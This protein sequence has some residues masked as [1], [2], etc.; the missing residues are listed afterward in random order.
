MQK[1]VEFYS[2]NYSFYPYA[3][4]KFTDEKLRDIFVSE[5]IRTLNNT[6]DNI[7]EIEKNEDTSVII[8]VIDYDKSYL[9]GIIGKLED[10]ENGLLKRLRNKD[11][12]KEISGEDEMP[13]FYLENFTYF[14]VR[15]EDMQCAVLSNR[16]AP[17]FRTHFS[18]FLKEI[19]K[20]L[21]YCSKT[22]GLEDIQVVCK[23]DNQIN[24]KLNKTK[25]LSEINM[26]FEDTSNIGRTLLDL[27]KSFHI[28]QSD[29]RRAKV[30]INLK[31]SEITE[32]T[33]NIFNN[34]NLIKSNFEK[35]EL[36]GED[37]ESNEI[38][39]ELVEKLLSK[40]IDIEI[41]EKYLRT[42]QDLNKIKEALLGAL[43]I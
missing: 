43:P 42:R 19:T 41:D 15:F 21:N 29:L 10:L 33:K 18:N 31:M 3:S 5:I 2:V 39:M 20:S 1:S 35:L 37:I 13:K 23:Y 34:E 27:S 7:F 16:S 30:Y 4:V 40:R 12:L 11:D 24:Y 25:R 36:I 26:I 22:A 17:R 9:F 38:Q 28:S 6:E 8:E 32:E 14:Y